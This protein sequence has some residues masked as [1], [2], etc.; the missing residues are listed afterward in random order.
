[1]LLLLGGLATAGWMKLMSFF[2]DNQETQ[3]R[4]LEQLCQEA[5]HRFND[6]TQNRMDQHRQAIAI[7]TEQHL[8][9]CQQACAAQTEITNAHF[10]TLNHELAATNTTV[11]DLAHQIGT[12]VT[13]IDTVD[14]HATDL[15]ETQ[16]TTQE[17]VDS[18]N[19]QV[20]HHID[21]TQARFNVLE[22]ELAATNNVVHDIADQA[23]TCSAR[24]NTIEHQTAE[25]LATTQ[26]IAHEEF[27][28][29]NTQHRQHVDTTYAQLDELGHTITR[30]NDALQTLRYQMLE[31]LNAQAPHRVPV[32][33]HQPTTP[34]PPQNTP[35][36]E[37]LGNLAAD[38]ATNALLFS[39]GIRKVAAPSTQTT[40][41]QTGKK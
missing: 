25:E 36:L 21:T 17:T 9:E 32:P 33:E 28:M 10:D 2:H 19:A 27:E 13:R 41:S 30:T 31:Q 22:H 12:C 15:E 37:Q 8:T 24:V 40:V 6:D 4:H 26:Q 35:L 16:H 11:H 1:L 38:T 20:Q 29:L 5:L 18:L 7:L 14:H 23:A 39:L 34:E 3:Q